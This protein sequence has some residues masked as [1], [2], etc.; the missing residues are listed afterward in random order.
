MANVETNATEWLLLLVLLTP[1]SVK[2]NFWFRSVVPTFETQQARVVTPAGLSQKQRLQEV[3]LVRVSIT[4][5]SYKVSLEHVEKLMQML[6]E[7]IPMCACAA[8]VEA[9][10]LGKARSNIHRSRAS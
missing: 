5:E 1:S 7:G 10:A 4:V 8:D 2:L 3:R 6:P 9:R